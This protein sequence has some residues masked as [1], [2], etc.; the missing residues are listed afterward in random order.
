MRMLAIRSA[1]GEF[2][3]A[4]VLIQ[5]A[6]RALL[7]G[8]DSPSLVLLAGLGP[9]EQSEAH[10]LFRAVTAELNLLSS[11]PDLRALRWELVRWRCEQIAA[12][13]LAP[14]VGGALIWHLWTDLDRPE[15]LQPLIA[16][17]SDW[18]EWSPHWNVHRESIGRGIAEEAQALLDGPTPPD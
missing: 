9:R 4:D 2:I 3:D 7:A 16:Q 10:D 17:V 15:R 6:L 18:Q 8:V 14:E 1:V 12:G 11:P 13:D 5:A